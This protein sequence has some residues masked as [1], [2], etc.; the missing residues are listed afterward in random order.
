VDGHRTEAP[1]LSIGDGTVPLR[2]EAKRQLEEER[3]ERLRMVIGGG[4]Q[5]I[6]LMTTCALIILVCVLVVILRS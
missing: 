4:Q 1:W 5:L 2:D 3:A 6:N